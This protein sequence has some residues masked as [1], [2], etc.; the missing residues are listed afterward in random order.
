MV[1]TGDRINAQEAERLGLVN[2]V[3]P[4]GQVYGVTLELA[5][6]IAGKSSYT[7]RLAKKALTYGLE[8]SS[9]D[10]ALFVERGAASLASEGEGFQEGVKAFLEKRPPN[11]K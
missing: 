6:K 8:A 10:V 4:K 5:K 11:F 1:Y 9:I 2:K 3:V 7:L